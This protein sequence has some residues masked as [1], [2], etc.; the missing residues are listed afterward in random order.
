MSL[1]CSKLRYWTCYACRTR[2]VAV[3]RVVEEFAE[4]IMQLEC[5]EL[6]CEITNEL[7]ITR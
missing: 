4:M 7:F 6:V 5:G 3:N 1:Y 2:L